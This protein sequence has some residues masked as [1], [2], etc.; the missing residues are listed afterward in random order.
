MR[1]VPHSMQNKCSWLLI[2]SHTEEYDL[3]EVAKE[4]SWS[5]WK[6]RIESGC[7]ISVQCNDCKE[8]ADCNYRGE[9]IHQRC[10]CDENVSDFECR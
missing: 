7:A 2:S 5:V 9:C 4:G 8:N 6:G 3:I 1:L 10:H